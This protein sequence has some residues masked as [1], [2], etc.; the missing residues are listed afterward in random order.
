MLNHN[1]PSEEE[2]PISQRRITPDELKRSLAALDAKQQAEQQRLADTLSVGQAVDDLSLDYT[3]E[4]VWQEVVRQREAMPP[5]LEEEPLES[6]DAESVSPEISMPYLR[7]EDETFNGNA[8]QY[9]SAPDVT[10][11]RRLFAAGIATVGLLVGV[12]LYRG[13]PQAPPVT[14]PQYYGT[15]APVVSSPYT[16]PLPVIRSP[17]QVATTLGAEFYK[18]LDESSGPNPVYHIVAVPID[19]NDAG[20]V[21]MVTSADKL[22]SLR[23]IPDGYSIYSPPTYNSLMGY[24][25]H[26]ITFRPADETMP[27]PIS[28]SNWP[29]AIITR[30]GGQPYLRCWIQRSDIPAFKTDSGFTLH[31]TPRLV[32]DAEAQGLIPITIPCGPDTH[33]NNP[34]GLV[35]R[36]TGR[37]IIA[38]TSIKVPAGF[39]LLSDKHTWEDFPNM[40]LTTYHPA[41]WT[42]KPGALTS[43]GGASNPYADFDASSDV[44]SIGSLRNGQIFHCGPLLLQRIVIDTRPGVALR[45]LSRFDGI[46]I[47]PLSE[48]LIDARPTLK[49]PYTFVKIDG[50]L[51]LRGWVEKRVTEAQIRNRY[52]ILHTD[53]TD[54]ELGDTPTQI[55][56]R[57][58]RC[59]VNISGGY[60]GTVLPLADVPLCQHAWEG[61]A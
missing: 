9:T 59:M 14:T 20:L 48:I 57:V 39:H 60:M 54:P 24:S 10:V 61:N 32:A 28:H 7:P 30:Y 53:P 51:Y 26:A 16:A 25:R 55:Q 42:N 5:E 56:V 47:G 41:D 4:E 49:R 8:A 35:A 44:K 22:Y 19:Q 21:T 17:L 13:Q 31:L 34:I 33:G 37:T 3:P 12:A 50:Q 1:E 58:D 2:I 45:K 36:S 38:V 46:Q 43:Q 18:K 15:Y 52:V 11:F 23:A 27:H 40:H 29:A 6:R